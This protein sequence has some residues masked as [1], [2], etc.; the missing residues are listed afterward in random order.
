[1]GRYSTAAE[2]TVITSPIRIDFGRVQDRTARAFSFARAQQGSFEPFLYYKDAAFR[3]CNS[4]VA[5]SNIL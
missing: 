3:G 2:A 1:M 4:G 5:K